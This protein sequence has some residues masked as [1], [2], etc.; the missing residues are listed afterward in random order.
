MTAHSSILTRKFPRCAAVHRRSRG[1]DA[2]TSV[3]GVT[4]EFH[5]APL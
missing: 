5:V 3:S 4:W 2:A 1:H